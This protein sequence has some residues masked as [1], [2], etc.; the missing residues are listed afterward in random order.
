[1]VATPQIA[2]RIHFKKFAAQHVADQFVDVAAPDE[3]AP[4]PRHPFEFDGIG[5]AGADIGEDEMRHAF[6]FAGGERQGRAAPERK[7]DECGALDLERVEHAHEIARQEACRITLR[8]RWSVRQAMAALIVGD[9]AK[10]LLQR[11]DLVQP[12]ALAAGKAVQQH[13]GRTI[14]GDADR[15]VQIADVDPVH[16]AFP[17]GSTRNACDMS[18]NRANDKAR[19]VQHRQSTRRPC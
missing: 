2:P 11:A 18:E 14:T 17:A 5:G 1:V 13:H 4:A 19:D 6:R 15:D 9:D 7:A 8:R 3:I 12:H 16:G 10:A